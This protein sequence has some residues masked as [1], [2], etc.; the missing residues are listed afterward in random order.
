LIFNTLFSFFLIS[1]VGGPVPC[2]NSVEAS[3]YL[4]QESVMRAIHVKKPPYHWSVCSNQIKYTPT[5]PNLPRDTY[6]ALNKF[7]RVLIYNGDWD[8]AV[9]YTDNEAW[10]TG[11]GYQVLN[12]WHPWYLF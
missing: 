4:N 12:S 1:K 5:R 8:S 7:T 9:P 6:P 10:T 2:I 11:M 3:A